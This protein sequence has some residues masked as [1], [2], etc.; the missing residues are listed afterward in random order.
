MQNRNKAQFQTKQFESESLRYVSSYLNDEHNRH[1]F[2]DS[3]AG[4]VKKILDVG[5]GNGEFLLAW[6]KHYRA[7]LAVGVEP[8][9]EAVELLQKKFEEYDYSVGPGGLEFQTAFAH[10]LPFE[11]D[12]F[13]IVTVWSV[14]HW[15]GRNE[16]L[17]SLGELIR[18][19]RG[20]LVIMDFVGQKDYRVP[21]SH[22]SGLFTYK[23]DFEN[24][25]VGSGIMEALEE[26]RWY[27]DSENRNLCLIEESQLNPFE[28]IINY[29]S[30]KMVV[31]KKNYDFLPVKSEKDFR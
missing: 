30:R 17:Q 29:H 13:D 27:V 25:I 9:R 2:P 7:E 16:Y 8:N 1:F 24:M 28:K 5:C 11:T 23:Q 22:K 15:I 26:K 19:C 18:V 4:K 20:Y 10:R 3:I 6:K 12:S 14:L 31:F 21:Y